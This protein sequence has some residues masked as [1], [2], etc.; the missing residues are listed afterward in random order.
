MNG[1]SHAKNAKGAKDGIE[2]NKGLRDSVFAGP[3]GDLGALCVISGE[4]CLTRDEHGEGA[5][6]MRDEHGKGCAASAGRIL[7]GRIPVLEDT[8][9]IPVHD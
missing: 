5:I 4:S 7:G 2:E 3:L 8:R 1:P 9:S 6:F